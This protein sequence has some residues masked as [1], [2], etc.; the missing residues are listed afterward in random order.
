MRADGGNV[1]REA[2]QD[3]L[4][5]D[6]GASRSSS[7][8]QHDEKSGAQQLSSAMQQQLA[9]MQH[10]MQHQLAMM[11]A[12]IEELTLERDAERAAHAAAAQAPANESDEEEEQRAEVEAPTM[13]PGGARTMTGSAQ[14]Q[15]AP[16][17]TVTAAA[18]AGVH[19]GGGNSVTSSEQSR[20]RRQRKLREPTPLTY[21]KAS[22]SSALED[23]IDGMELMFGHGQLEL[24]AHEHSERLCEINALV[25][26]DLRRWWTTQRAEAARQGAPINTWEAFVAALRTQFQPL[27]E[28][29]EARSAFF[30]IRQQPGE[31]MERYFLRATRLFAR[32]GGLDDSTAMHLVLDRVCKSEWRYAYALATREVQAGSITTLAQLRAFL[33]REALAE[34]SKQRA[35][36]G[37]SAP[38]YP[39]KKQSSGGYKK[40]AVRAAAAAIESEEESVCDVSDSDSDGGDGARSKKAAAAQFRDNARSGGGAA[41][42]YRCKEEGHTIA[43]CTKPDKRECFYCGVKGHLKARCP[44][45]AEK[46]AGE[47]GSSAQKPKNA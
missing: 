13:A 40:Q 6:D 29:R 9:A 3:D 10:A 34:P 7:G 26:R 22:S 1:A 32:A 38:N 14:Q 21:D 42:C 15:Q 23:W 46:A 47:G 19:G 18:A 12:R 25:D 2:D 24:E 30:D 5:D 4:V 35:S 17:A 11:Q 16:A 45:R 37:S 39:A 36:G 43:E 20:A 28:Q 44:K 8:A 41:R 31:A 33:Q 27:T